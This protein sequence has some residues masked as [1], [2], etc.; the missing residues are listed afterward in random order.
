M[1]DDD[2]T[3]SVRLVDGDGEPISNRWIMVDYGFMSGMEKRYTDHDGWCEFPTLGKNYVGTISSYRLYSILILQE[4]V[5]LSEGEE[6][7][8]GATFSFTIIDG[9]EGED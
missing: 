3:F 5:I 6:I 4:G 2:G 9:D 1:S 7:S 8:N